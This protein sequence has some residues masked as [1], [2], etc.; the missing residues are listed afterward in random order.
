[1]KPEHSNHRSYCLQRRQLG[2]E[3]NFGGFDAQAT[4]SQTGGAE[5]FSI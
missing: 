3:R 4:R 5:Q 1:M 2:Q